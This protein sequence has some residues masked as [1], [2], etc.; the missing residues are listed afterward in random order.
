MG[1]KVSQ[2]MHSGVEWVAPNASLRDVARLMRTKDIGSVPVGEDDR[3]V[4]MVTDRDIAL[5]GFGNGKDASA[6]TARDVMTKPIVY[7]RADDAIEDALRIME[8]RQIRRLPVINT[9]KR[10][11]GMLALGDI[12]HCGHG[13]LTTEFVEAVSEHHA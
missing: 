12:S 6:L 10:M 9:D 2:A 7:C 11:V 5:R 1:T 3:L 8:S 4:G 13:E